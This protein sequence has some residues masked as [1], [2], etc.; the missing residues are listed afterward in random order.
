[1][2]PLLLLFF[3]AMRYY[4]CME[5]TLQVKNI[6]KGSPEAAF[7]NALF[8]E[9]FPQIERVDFDLLPDCAENGK[10]DFF[11]FSDGASPIGFAFV[12]LPG[13]YAYVLF[14]AIDG[15]FRDRGYG[16]AILKK[17]KEHYEGR[18]L[19]LDVEPPDD[20]AANSAQ[21]VSR[22]RFYRKNGFFDLGFEMRDRT[23]RFR[24]L[25]DRPEFDLQSFLESYALL[26]EIF[27]ATEIYR[28]GQEDPVYRP[29]SENH[30]S[31]P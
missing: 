2:S 14:Y 12:L 1:M 26:P 11:A 8:E 27:P 17:L 5:Y 23:G 9:A 28:D 30:R 7:A 16:A 20:T 25:S 22:Y 21:R 3:A 24:L 18:P 6:R 29:G 19:I 4:E 10:A 15:R 31:K 13:C